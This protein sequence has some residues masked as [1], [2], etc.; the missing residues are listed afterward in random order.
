MR[1][2]VTGSSGL[3]GR[4]LVSRLTADGHRVAVLV[5]RTPGPG[6]ARWDPERGQIDAHALDGAEAVVHLA[7]AGIG[8][9]RWTTARKDVIL[10]SRV[11]ATAV[12]CRCLAGLDRRPSVVISAS[13]IGYYGDR[14]DEV[15][16]ERSGPGTGFQAEV[17]RRW[18]EATAPAE[19]AGIRVVHLR[20]G[21]VLARHGGA[22]GRQLPLFRAGLGAT[23]GSGRQWLSWISLR[24]EVGAIVHALADTSLVGPVNATAPAPVTNR[25]FTKELGH[26]LHRPAVLGAP[27]FALRLALGRQLADEL[28][29]GSLRVVPARLADAGYTFADP[30]LEGALR[31]TLGT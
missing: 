28:L 17:C 10:R 3:I 2:V 1:V 23:L 14:G 8:D 12:L 30:T 24:D 7:G 20:S 31:Q 21:V 9:K 5:R 25:E 16:T 29:L 4:A 13:A 27:P 22:L 6:E 18:E 11:D 15:L 19:A 26:A